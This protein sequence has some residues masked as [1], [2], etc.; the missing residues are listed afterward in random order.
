VGERV[1]GIVAVRRRRYEG[2]GGKAEGW[3][4]LLK[5]MKV[6]ERSI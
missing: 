5:I 4:T 3:S 2:D 1:G 6:H